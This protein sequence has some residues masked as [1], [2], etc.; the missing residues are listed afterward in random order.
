MASNRFS[1]KPRFLFILIILLA[2]LFTPVYM[3]LNSKKA[4]LQAELAEAQAKHDALRAQVQELNDKINH[5]KTDQGIEQY[6]R[7][8]GM[9]MPGEISYV[10][11]NGSN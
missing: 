10:A 3:H 8:A 5:L 1:I 11:G 6:A 2:I 4:E 7:A 9:I